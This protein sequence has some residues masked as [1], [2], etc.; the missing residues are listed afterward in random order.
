M[1]DSREV[2]KGG[3]VPSP[4]THSILTTGLPLSITFLVSQLIVQDVVLAGLISLPIAMLIGLVVH[5]LLASFYRRR[6]G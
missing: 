3:G 4:W 6:S 1:R 2:G 5:L